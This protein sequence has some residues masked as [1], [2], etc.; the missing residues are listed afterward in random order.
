MSIK[1]ETY[2]Y[3]VVSRTNT[4]LGRLIQRKLGVAYNHC[5]ISL[6]ASLETI[7]SFGRKELRNIFRAGFVQESKSR[8]FFK[9]HNDSGIAVVR[10]SVSVEEYEQ[11][12]K[13][14]KEFQSQQAQYK[15]SMLGLLYCYLG[16]P[17]KR[18]DKYFC[19]QF[20][21]EVLLKAGLTLFKKPETLVRPHDFL[22]LNIGE[23]IYRGQISNYRLV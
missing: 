14:L 13:I 15:Y 6:D 19:S 23:L 17:H 2:I 7:Y 1:N 10:I 16:I 21:A 18:K 22:S 9:E 5:S 4:T 11:I 20:V 12:Y 3:I 8:G